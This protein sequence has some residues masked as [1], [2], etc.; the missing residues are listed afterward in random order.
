MNETIFTISL[1][2][3]FVSLIWIMVLYTNLDTKRAELSRYI[4]HH[5]KFI[6]LYIIVSRQNRYLLNQI[7]KLHEAIQNAIFRPGLYTLENA[8][9]WYKER[10]VDPNPPDEGIS[11][12]E[13]VLFYV[14]HERLRAKNLKQRTKDVR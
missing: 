9:N 7:N 8:E 12:K 13:Q 14:R 5:Q 4:D 1:L 10:K 2:W 11:G 3:S 6:G